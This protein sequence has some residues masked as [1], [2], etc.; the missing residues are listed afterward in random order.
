M[1]RSLELT[2]QWDGIIR[3][4]PVSPLSLQ[5]FEMAGSGGLGDWLQ[6]VEGLNRRLS[7]GIRGWR[8][9]LREE[10][11]FKWL[12]ADLVPPAP[13]LQC[14]PLVTPVGSG[15]LAARG[16]ID[17]EFR[18][19]WL[20]YFC[21]S[22]QQGDSLEEFDRE[23]DGSLFC[24]RFPCLVFLERCLLRFIV[25]VLLLEVWMAGMAGVQGSPGFLV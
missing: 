22:G 20:P 15:V 1:S 25:K 23:V 4:G 10:S 9:W 18:K 16:R 2:V 13:F 8:N 5:D 17:E 11:L 14:D 12:R 3:I 24:R 7:E 21:R 6:V 19:A